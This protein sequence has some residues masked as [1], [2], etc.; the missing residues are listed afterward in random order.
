MN[1]ARR[2]PKSESCEELEA[3]FG[4]DTGSEPLSAQGAFSFEDVDCMSDNGE[5]EGRIVVIW[6]SGRHRRSR[7]ASNGDRFPQTTPTI[8]ASKISSNR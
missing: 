1:G 4:V 3:E 2:N 8:V 5:I 7:P 6:F